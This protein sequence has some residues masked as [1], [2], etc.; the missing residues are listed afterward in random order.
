[1]NTEIY[2]FEQFVNWF[3][4]LPFMLLPAIIFGIL[5]TILLGLVIKGN[6]NFLIDLFVKQ[7]TQRIFLISSVLL[8]IVYVGV[9]FISTY[10]C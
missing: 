5:T 2:N 6:T 1:M 3:L 4:E 9:L 10:P 7:D 8:S